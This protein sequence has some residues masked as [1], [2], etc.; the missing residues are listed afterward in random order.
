MQVG[1]G[2]GAQGSEVRGQ[3]SGLF[4]PAGL[5]AGLP[6]CAHRHPDRQAAGYGKLRAARPPRLPVPRS[7][8]RSPPPTP[9]PDWLVD[10]RH[11][12]LRWQ[13]QVSAV[14]QKIEAALRDMPEHEE[15][16]QLLAGAGERNL[17][18]PSPLPRAS[19]HLRDS[20]VPPLSSLRSHS[21][22]ALPP[23]R[24]HPQGHR[25]LHQEPLWAILIPAHEGERGWLRV[26]H[27]CA[28]LTLCFPLPRTGRRSWPSMRRTTPTW[29]ARCQQAQQDLARR[30]EEC[31]LAAAELRE[32]FYTSCKQYGI[33]GSNVRQE[34]LALV[35]DLPSLLSE[36]G[37][38]V[39]ALSEAIELYQ[40]CVEFVCQ[41]SEGPVVPMLRY[42]GSKGNTTVY[43]WRTGFEPVKVERPE[44]QVVPEQPKE[45]TIDWGDFTLEPIGG[46]DADNTAA[47]GEAQDNEIDWGI[48]VEPSTQD[49]GIDW[50]DGESNEAQITVLEDGSEEPEAVARGSD[51]LTLLENAATRNQFIDELMELELFLAQRLVEMEEEARCPGCQPVP[52]GPRCPAGPDQHPCGHTAGQH[53]G[54]AGPAEHP[55]HAA[56]LHHPRLPQVRGPCERD[57]AAET[58]P[59]RAAAGQAGGTE[60]EAA[61]GSDRAGCAGAQAGPPAGAD[62]GAAAADRS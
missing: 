61:G 41:S 60:P 6:G 43:E 35:Q 36:V 54:A 2:T 57:A 26:P 3:R 53:Q 1:T 52:A 19:V 34:L 56:S 38:G 48:V 39:G 51:A 8:G 42:V 45:D 50:G 12:G 55:P 46:G 22:L 47:G 11:C 59:S 13:A 10:R 44:V 21:L 58:E 18:D 7:S 49:N 23:H 62:P 29:I 16:A 32:R 27:A 30:E 31:Q 15:I 33:T 40:A 25:S 17:N 24:G 9:P 20:V 28:L 37:A 5:S 4:P 14:R